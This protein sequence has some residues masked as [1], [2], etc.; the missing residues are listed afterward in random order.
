M[1]STI[2]RGHSIGTSDLDNALFDSCKSSGV[3]WLYQGANDLL[4]DDS[5]LDVNVKGSPIPLS[6]CRL[7]RCLRQ[8]T[9]DRRSSAV[10]F[11]CQT[12]FYAIDVAATDYL[13]DREF[14]S[15]LADRATHTRL[16]R[17]DL[18]VHPAVVMRVPL[19]PVRAPQR[20]VSHLVNDAQWQ[21][22]MRVVVE[23]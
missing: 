14:P 2:S 10:G 19:A 4:L 20:A 3:P 18:G 5:L 15:G 21:Q 23:R 13:V 16:Q 22:V 11:L 12:T 9:S 1:D 17:A 8:T 6:Q 7:I